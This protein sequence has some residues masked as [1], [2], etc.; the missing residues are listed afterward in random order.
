MRIKKVFHSLYSILE[1]T[2]KHKTR[3]LAGFVC[4]T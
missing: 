2:V 4:S 1:L 3:Q